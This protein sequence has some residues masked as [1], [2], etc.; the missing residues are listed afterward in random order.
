MTLPSKIVQRLSLTGLLAGV[1]CTGV[2]CAGRRVA[3]VSPA[4]IPEIEA[5]LARNPENG[6]LR[7]RY[8][9]ALFAADRC[10]QAVAEARRARTLV[11]Q[12]AV[13]VLVI[14]QCLE[15]AGNYEQALSEYRSYLTAFPEARG[16]AAVRAREMLAFRAY[17]TQLARLAL[18]NEAQLAQ[19]PGDP[20]TIAVLPLAIAGDTAEYGALSRGLAQII[21]SDLALIR[22]FRLVE[23][24]QLNALLQELQLSE[25]G[26]VDP[27]TA[28]RV[29]RLIQAGRL[30][31]GLAAIPPEG[32]V[33][34]EANVV[35]PTGEVVGP[36][37]V[38]GRFRDLLRL[39]KDLVIQLAG[40]LGY[41]LS[42]AERRLIL[43]NGTQNLAAFLAY[44]RGL[45]AE[46]LGDYQAAAQFYSQAVQADPGFQQARQQYQT[47]A[48]A[49]VVQQAAPGQVTTVAAQPPP[50]P[51]TPSE[52][53]ASAVASSTADVAGTQAEST[54][55]TTTQQQQQAPPPPV[56]VGA[57]S[58][59]P[60]PTTS[61]QGTTNTVTGIIRILFRLP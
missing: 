38:S 14:G 44:S 40:R 18:Q 50:P 33:R 13:A 59:D 48:T 56:V 36:E 32:E 7:A 10:E 21:M 34:L 60:P 6:P 45:V 17:S 51:T 37:A 12:D 55:Q 49:T 46:D 53:A 27:A 4:E 11:P 29:G 3:E 31:Q 61:N 52:P 35:L 1:I 20:N 5:A 8:A 42:E 15:R 23:R 28:A 30:V 2:A 57:P 43:E 25:A 54:V 58:S 24:I 22:R 9:A 16:S 19:Q 39:E 26:R 47:A 41:F